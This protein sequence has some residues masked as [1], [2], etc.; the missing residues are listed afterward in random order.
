MK[1]TKNPFQLVD[2][3]VINAKFS[4]VPN[5]TRKSIDEIESEY[6][7]NVD[8]R[9]EFEGNRVSVYSKVAVNMNSS[10]IPLPGYSIFAEGVS[11]FECDAVH[12]SKMEDRIKYANYSGVPIGLNNLRCFIMQ[13]TSNGPFGKYVLPTLN[14][15]D[16]MQQKYKQVS[17]IA[18]K[19][20]RT[21]KKALQRKAR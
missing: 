7:L 5:E 1:P 9:F 2:F 18:G 17:S 10:S 20:S 13:L 15:K 4:F 21:K 12:I 8:Y 6:I 11:I 19:E 14:L 3:V 16:L